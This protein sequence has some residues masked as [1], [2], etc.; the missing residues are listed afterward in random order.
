MR[1]IHVWFGS[2]HAVKGVNLTVGKSEVLGLI[3]DNGAGKST[4]V[5]VLAGII[6]SKRGSIYWKRKKIDINSVSDSRDLKIETVYQDRAVVDCRTVAQNI[7]LGRELMRGV[8]PIK[9]LDRRRMNNEAREVTRN[10]GLNI[11]SLEQE[12]RFC[13]GGERQ[14]IAI[15]RAMKQEAELVILDEPTTAL[16]VTGVRKVL[17]YIKKLK[18]I[19]VSIIVITHNLEH[20]FPVADR[21]VVLFK[22]EK[23]ADVKKEKISKDELVELQIMGRRSEDHGRIPD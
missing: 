11:P 1:D 2:V 7:F 18:G 21:F 15:A 12:V 17:A 13:S 6:R 22:G 10:L 4:L 23:V 16:S 14:G 9:L 8:G 20:V 19:G 5:K 3:G